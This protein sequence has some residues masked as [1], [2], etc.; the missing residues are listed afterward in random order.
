[1]GHT[2]DYVHN[3]RFSLDYCRH[4]PEHHLYTFVLIE[5]AE[6]QNSSSAFQTEFV[7]VVVTVNEWQIRY[8]VGDQSYFS[9][10][11]IVN[12]AQHTDAALVHRHYSIRGIAD[13]H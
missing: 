11:Y 13:L 1:M 7:L 6:C 12:V 4:R 2:Q 3:R 8:A 5:Q 9:A 10:R